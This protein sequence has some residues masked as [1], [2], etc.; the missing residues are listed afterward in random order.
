MSQQHDEQQGIQFTTIIKPERQHPVIN[1]EEVWRYRGL[2]WMFMLR[3]IKVRYKQTVL[4][5]TWAILQPILTMLV[6]TVIFGRIAKIPSDGVPYPIFVYSGLLAWNFFNSSVSTAGSSLI[7]AS[8]LITK[9]YF[10]R[11]VVPIATIG[12]SVV[13]FAISTVILILMMLLYG[14]SPSADLW[15]LPFLLLGLFITTVG[16]SAWLSAITVTFRD[17][18]FIIPFALQIWM[19]LTPIIYPISFIPERWQFLTYFN[20]IAGWISAIR[21]VFLDLPIDWVGIACSALWAALLLYFGLR[22]FARVER[23]FADI[24]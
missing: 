14:I 12:V 17:F 2:L 4:G 22:Y 18:R 13:E 24:I 9:V 15:F 8:N 10:P 1:F 21:A 16:I 11:I 19:Y 3:D 5:I 7:S 6:F 20:P 23:R